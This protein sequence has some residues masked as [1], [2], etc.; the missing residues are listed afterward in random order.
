MLRVGEIVKGDGNPLMNVSPNYEDAVKKLSQ[1]SFS[2]KDKELLACLI[3]SQTERQYK[4]YLIKVLSDLENLD[5]DKLVA[6]WQ[7]GSLEVDDEPLKN[8]LTKEE[9]E[10]LN[11]LDIEPHLEEYEDK[12]PKLFDDGFDS[13]FYPTKK[14]G[15]LYIRRLVKYYLKEIE[16]YNDLQKLIVYFV[17][18]QLLGNWE[19]SCIHLGKM[20]LENWEI[21]KKCDWFSYIWPIYYKTR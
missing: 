5:A 13:N 17:M 16:K 2:S 4:K 18:A 10:L 11:E 3:L 6:V 21:N 1:Y 8:L 14:K 7:K 15:M 9:F 20:L 19:P 12:F